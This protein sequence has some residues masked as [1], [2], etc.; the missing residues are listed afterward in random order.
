M[1]FLDGH[2][3]DTD[4]SI[5]K[6]R[7]RKRVRSEESNSPNIPHNNV[8]LFDVLPEGEREKESGVREKDRHNSTFVQQRRFTLHIQLNKL[9]ELF[10]RDF[11]LRL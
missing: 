11:I 3:I 9:P 1:S 10:Y 2:V 6:R 8:E 5:M 4:D 7:L